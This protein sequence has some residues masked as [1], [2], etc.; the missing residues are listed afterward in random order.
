MVGLAFKSYELSHLIT[1]N[2]HLEDLTARW[3]LS[4]IY[5]Q[6]LGN[7][8]LQVFTVGSWNRIVFAIAYLLYKSKQISPPKSVI[9]RAELMDN[10]A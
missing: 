7:K 1:Y 8:V 6:Q 5:T 2:F 3:S 10:T 9:E 4:R